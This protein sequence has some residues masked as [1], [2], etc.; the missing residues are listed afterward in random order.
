[1]Y[2]HSCCCI[3]FV[4]WSSFNSNWFYKFFSKG[5]SKSWKN[6]KEKISSSPPCLG[7]GPLL[8]SP[9]GLLSPFPFLSRRGP[10]ASTA[11]P[12]PRASSL[13]AAAADKAD[14]HPVPLPSGPHLS[15]LSSTSCP[16]R[17]RAAP[18][19]RACFARAVLLPPDS[20]P[21]N[22]RPDAR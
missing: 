6:K 10:S 13:L 17:T 4:E 12:A 22:T 21:L 3:Y 9:R 7:L 11:Q 8:S 19:P 18:Q 16:S 15:V 2:V 14:P 5:L 20:R 1:M